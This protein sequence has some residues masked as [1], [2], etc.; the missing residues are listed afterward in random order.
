MRRVLVD[1]ARK[2]RA[3]KRTAGVTATSLS[4]GGFEEPATVA[5]GR[6]QEMLE[7][8]EALGRLAKLNERLSKT[9]ELR[10]FGGMT[11]EEIAEALELAPST[12]SLDWKKA[13]AWLH[14]EL[15]EA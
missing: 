3:L 9:V 14:R 10:F 13:R 1:Y 12:V 11:L 2:H 8:D 4:P 15:K 6:A 7:L 5:A